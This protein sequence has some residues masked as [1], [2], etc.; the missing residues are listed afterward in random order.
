VNLVPHAQ[1]PRLALALGAL[2]ACKER[3]PPRPVA[4][5]ARPIAVDAALADANLDGCRATAARLASLPRHAR[6]QALLDACQ[7]CGDWQ[8][9]L[10]WST[11]PADGGPAR[12]AIERAMLACKAYCEPNAKQRFLGTLDA[13]R[14]QSTRGPWRYLGEI[15]KAEVSA[16]PDSR[17]MG[18]PYFALDR[19]ARALGEPSGRTAI[20]VALPALSVTGVGIELAAAGPSAAEASPAA[21]TVHAGEI[22][23]GALPSATLSPT[24]LQVTGDYPGAPIDRAALA[25]ALARRELADQPIALLAPSGLPASRIVDVVGAAGGH[26]LRLAV[27]A[28]GPGGWLLPT[29]VP[30]ALLATP[31]ASSRRLTLAASPGS[32]IDGARAARSGERPGAA[33]PRPPFTIVVEPAAT[34]AG[35]AALLDALAALEVTSVAVARPPAKP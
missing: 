28:P 31:A 20:E 27:G 33:R 26:A 8:P 15:C 13:A 35:L 24:G 34:V 16:V 4:E 2:V 22:L 6:A 12:A 10:T 7:P 32:A 11:L 18:G 19:I 25:A 29:V 1:L 17:F 3:Q 30:V 23:L 9:L 21:L 5:P 14:G